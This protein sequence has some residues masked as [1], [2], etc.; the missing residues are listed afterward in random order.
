MG[1]VWLGGGGSGQC[2]W[3]DL[4]VP[5][6][7]GCGFCGLV[8][9]NLMVGGRGGGGGL[10]WVWLGGGGGGGGGRGL[11]V[12]AVGCVGNLLASIN[13]IILL[14]KNIILMSRIGK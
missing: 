12:G 9:G 13:Y 4:F 14:C 6:F 10:G 5:W 11:V 8:V 2:V 3:S 7:G 1:W